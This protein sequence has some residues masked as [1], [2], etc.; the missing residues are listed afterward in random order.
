MSLT[1]GSLAR[2][3]VNMPLS[4]RPPSGFD[5]AF[6][7]P[8][9]VEPGLGRVW[10]SLKS[11]LQGMISIEKRDDALNRQ[12]SG[13]EERLIR[14][15]LELQLGSARLAL[16]REQGEP[17]RQGLAAAR[18]LLQRYFDTADAQVVSSLAL[19]E[20]LLL[21]DVQPARPDISGSLNMLRTLVGQAGAGQ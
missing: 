12:L 20:E 10:A 11:A 7:E 9:D 3:V 6:A 17:Y 8:D 19:L 4:A 18:D 21:V 16:L 13:E 2:R 15:N 5:R 1:V 14:R